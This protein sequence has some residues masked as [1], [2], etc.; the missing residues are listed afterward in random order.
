MVFGKWSFSVHLKHRYY[1]IVIRE[2]FFFVIAEFFYM[3]K[4]LKKSFLVVL[5]CL[6]GKCCKTSC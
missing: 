3:N 4:K 6:W 5:V 1:N 2:A